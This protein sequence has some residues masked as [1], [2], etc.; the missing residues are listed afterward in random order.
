MKMLR[1][2]KIPLG[3]FKSLFHFADH[4]VPQAIFEGP[5]GWTSRCHEHVGLTRLIGTLDKKTVGI[6]FFKKCTD[7]LIGHEVQI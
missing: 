3:L 1:D 7:I 4:A 2:Q 5:L 6:S